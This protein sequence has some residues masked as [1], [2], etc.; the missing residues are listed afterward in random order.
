MELGEV[1]PMEYR[2]DYRLLLGIW[3]LIFHKTSLNLVVALSIKFFI[4]YISDRSFKV[5]KS[6]Y[7]F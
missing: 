4:I 7:V 5:V 3:C 2:L 6:M 1:I